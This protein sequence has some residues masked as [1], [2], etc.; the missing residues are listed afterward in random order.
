[1]LFRREPR[2]C[3]TAREMEDHGQPGSDFFVVYTDGRQ[4][5]VSGFPLL[6]TRTF[7]VKLTKLFRF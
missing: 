6:Q 5:N 7:A 2:A 1:M 4:T 3:G